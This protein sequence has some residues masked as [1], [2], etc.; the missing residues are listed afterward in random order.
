M[1]VLWCKTTDTIDP[2]GPYTEDNIHTAS[3][4]LYKLTGEKYP[5]VLRTTE[6]YSQDTDLST[7]TQPALIGGQMYNIPRSGNAL[8]ELSLRHQPVREVHRVTYLGRDL[9][10]SEYS[11]R[12]NSFIVLKNRQP[13]ILSHV[14]E[15]EVEYSYGMNP[16]R[17]GRKAAIRFANELILADK[18]SDAC[19]LPQR[20]TSVN[21]Q[22]VS[23]TMLD[24]QD[25]VKDGRTGI[26]EIDLFLTAV[27]PNKSQKRAKVYSPGRPFG[28]KIG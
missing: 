2:T 23:F 8:T 15:L 12:N 28:E 11:L 21:R 25:F 18:G 3:F 26:Y 27:N 9:D 6:V 16:P 1:A 19:S 7:A 24:P 20:V 17:A 4:I 5:G 14:N 13:W 22:G 10:P